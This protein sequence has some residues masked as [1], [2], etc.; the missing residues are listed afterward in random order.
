MFFGSYVHNLDTKG[1]LVIP[2]KLREEAGLSLFILKG[3][4]GAL[5]IYKKEGF[6]KLVEE[7]KTLPF[8]KENSRAYLR[9]QLASAHELEVD[10]QGRIQLPVQLLEKYKI[11][12]E[13]I[14]IG[15]GDHME[16]WN[17]STYDEYESAVDADFEGIA[18]SLG[19][20]EE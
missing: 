1:R 6:D 10:K 16:V 18:E 8:N 17:K 9:V 11:G 13:V 7:I 2:S 20:L 5:S 19:K 12:K 15:V 14:V 3:F 4:D